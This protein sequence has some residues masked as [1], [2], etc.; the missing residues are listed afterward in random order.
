KEMSVSVKSHPKRIILFIFI[1]SVLVFFFCSELVYS[2]QTEPNESNQNQSVQKDKKDEL[3]QQYIQIMKL[4]GKKEYDKVIV[5][6]KKIIEQDSSFYRVYPTLVK[7]KKEKNELN[8]TIKYFQELISKDPN[9]TYFYYGS[10]LCYKEQEDY[11]KAIENFKRCIELK[12]NFADV[13]KELVDC[14]QKKKAFSELIDYF[15]KNIKINPINPGLYYGLGYIYSKLHNY[16]KALEYYEHDLKIVKEIGDR[17]GEIRGF[18]NIAIIYWY[19]GNPSKAL[20]YFEQ[21]LKIAEEIGDKLNE[22]KNLHNISIIYEKLDDYLKALEYYERALKI[23]REISDKKAEGTCLN[24][25]GVV[26]RKSDNYSKAL[27]Y[28]EQ[29]L[30]INR[31]IGNKKVEGVCLNNIGIVYKGLGNYSKALEYYEQAL[32]IDREIGNKR[33]EG[34]CLNN[35]GLA[36]WDLGNYSRALEYYEQAL[37]IDR[38][39]GYRWAEAQ[40]LSNIGIIYEN[41]GNYS[42]ALEYYEQA[43]KIDREI[44]NKMS[45]GISL[46]NMGHAYKN[47]GNYFKALEYHEQ[48]L[49]IAQGI[50]SKYIEGCTLNGV[51]DIYYYKLKDYSKSAEFYL[52]ALAIGQEIGRSD[53][54]WDAHYGLASVYEKQEKFSQA[55]KH[56]KKAIEIIEG[57]R[58]QLQLGEWKA[59]FLKSKIEIYESLI[60]LLLKLHQQNPSKGYDKEA[61]Y[62][63]E[64]AKARAFLD[65]LQEAKIDFKANLTT[66]LR[67]QERK[68]SKEISQI[69]THLQE[70]NLSQEKREELFKELEKAEDDYKSLIA[71]TRRENPEYASI[72]YPDPYKVKEVQDKL[73]DNRTALIEYFIGEENSFGFL[74]TKD[75]LFIESMLESKSLTE[76][77][78]NYIPYLTLKDVKEFKAIEGSKRSYDILIGP[79]K[80]KLNKI[81]KIIIVPDRNLN[82]LP[83][84]T[85]ILSPVRGRPSADIGRFLIEDYKISYAPSASSLINLLER[86]SVEKR[87][88]DLL[89]I[90][91]PVF[92]IE[93]K[94]KAEPKL[95]E[96]I[97]ADQIIRGDYFR[98]GFSLYPLAFASEEI[99]S[100][101]K[102]FKKN[103]K[104]LFLKEKALEENIKKIELNKF[105]IIH[106]ATHGLLD[107]K[108][109]DRSTLVLTLDKDPT[110]DGFLQA[111]EIYNLKLNADLVV[112]SACQTA[113]GKLEKGEGITGLARAFLYPGSKSVLSSLWNINDKSTAQFMKYFYQYLAEGKTKTQALRLAKIKMI[114]SKY[115]HP[116]YWAA[117]ILIGD[118][119]SSIKISIPSFWERF[120]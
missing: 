68:I 60:N 11:N 7:A 26:Y 34:I 113:K 102:F 85:L 114:N 91:D 12:A 110:E 84:E 38:E 59:G 120:F 18:G 4:M 64:K 42:K 1:L 33:S 28:Y 2:E 32:K 24:N 70:P 89:A 37:K 10:G 50:G 20:R 99:K 103:L 8:E 119:D 90:G 82:Y 116:F 67:E 78:N 66:E 87:E 98:K 54:L 95:V 19:L 31:E 29:A 46:Y 53:I 75:N 96:P 81:E 88:R 3:N 15:E 13:Y 101:S 100:I 118:Y 36:Y 77:V 35:I 30:I 109:G 27:E 40:C 52:N 107:D 17:R 61:F 71:K 74:V 111:R 104:E 115:S 58:A 23:F 43:L 79:F 16:N 106:F 108:N 56:Y 92:Q 80:D 112:L 63:T 39:I 51:G 62:F 86:K 49:K 45:E 9:N 55:L 41:V 6:C 72:I 22:G 14:Y 97:K 69:L 105:K 5:E 25:I 48:G 57:I 21:G 94:K 83:F 44:G 65:S 117:F 76:M 93:E 73:L 47:L